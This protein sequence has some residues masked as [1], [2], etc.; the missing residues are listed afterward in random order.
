[1]PQSSS[2]EMH[3]KQFV[4]TD[5]FVMGSHIIQVPSLLQGIQKV[6]LSLYVQCFPHATGLEKIVFCIKNRNMVQ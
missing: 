6:L 3:Y 5:Q 4:N 2:F 1:M